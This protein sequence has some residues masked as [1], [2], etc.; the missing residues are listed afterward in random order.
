MLCFKPN[1]HLEDFGKKNTIWKKIIYCRHFEQLS[2]LLGIKPA[3]GKWIPE[4]TARFSA[5]TSG[6]KLQARVNS[7]SRDGAGMELI[8]NSTG[9]P[10]VINEMLTYENFAIK[11]YLQGK[12]NLP[13]KSFYRKGN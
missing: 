9:H 2:Y 3:S 7:F 13:K 10:K 1:K 5:Y 8:D 6:I 11:E 12:N 4:A